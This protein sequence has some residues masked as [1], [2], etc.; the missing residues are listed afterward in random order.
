MIVRLLFFLLL[1]PAAPAA[2]AGL[3]FAE[4]A[5]TIKATPQD[6]SLEARYKFTNSG[7]V[8]IGIIQLTTSCGCTVAVTDKNIYQP[9][10]TGVLTATYTI[11]LSEGRHHYTITLQTSEE[12]VPPYTLQFTAELPSGQSPL[13]ANAVTA[14]LTPG[15]LTWSRQPY[16]T[17]TVAIDLQNIPGTKISASCDSAQFQLTLDE[18]ASSAILHVTPS[19]TAASTR[20][21]V[22]L[23]FTPPNGPAFTKKI[24]L[25]I[26]SLKPRNP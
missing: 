11:G 12:N 20:A 17:K 14:R 23:Q 15:E 13:I 16:A 3:E 25:L 9:G 1:A 22:I 21:E 7:S 5:L 8:P 4:T 24:P 18:S 26:L 2:Y 19:Q 10:D 6:K